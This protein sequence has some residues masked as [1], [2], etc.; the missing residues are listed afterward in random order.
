MTKVKEILHNKKILAIIIS[1]IVLLI[2]IVTIFIINSK[3]ITNLE[4]IKIE[5][6]CDKISNYLDEI[7]LEEDDDGK[8][9]NFA[10]EY[11]Y[12]EKNK[13]E[14]S[15]E[16]VLEVIND[17]FDISYNEEDLSKTGISARMLEKNIVY[18]STANLFKYKFNKTQS[19]IANSIIVKYG[20]RKMK[21]INKKMFE[22]TLDKYVVE[23]PYEILNYYN[24]YNIRQNDSSKRYNTDDI[25]KYLKGKENVKVIKD[26][27]N[28][29]NIEEFGKIDGSV[30]ITFVIKD[31]KLKIK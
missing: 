20:L 23:N 12:N 27:I 4:K 28:K 30:K 16:E 7:Y 24:D 25:V 6:T 17:T 3:K 1:V 14:F 21:K 13:E 10:I 18:D 2:V 22:V 11:L 29:D 19:D 5:E 9:I 31:N 15:L 26:L 8:Y